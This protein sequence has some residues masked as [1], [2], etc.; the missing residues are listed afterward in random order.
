MLT[1][2]ILRY[3]REYGGMKQLVSLIT[4]RNSIDRFLEMHFQDTV[5]LQNLLN[6][7]YQ[8]ETSYLCLKD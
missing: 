6:D 4:D 1:Y 8:I 2:G 5:A 7:Q 3:W